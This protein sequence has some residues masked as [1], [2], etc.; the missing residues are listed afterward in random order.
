M[1]M[2]ELT[3]P[4]MLCR[5]E[6]RRVAVVASCPTFGGQELRWSAHWKKSE[7]VSEQD[8]WTFLTFVSLDLGPK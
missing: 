2:E 5:V 1:M 7:S 4:I 3:L 6:K 8:L